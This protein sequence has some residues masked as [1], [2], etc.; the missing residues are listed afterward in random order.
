ML[1]IK[2]S[3]DTDETNELE[4]INSQSLF[5]S[6]ADDFR[7]WCLGLSGSYRGLTN[8]SQTRLKEAQS[9]REK[10]VRFLL[11]GDDFV[12]RNNT[13]Q[14]NESDILLAQTRK[15][16]DEDYDFYQTTIFHAQN[17]KTALS[18]CSSNS[19]SSTSHHDFDLDGSKFVKE[20][21]ELIQTGNSYI[22]NAAAHEP[23]GKHM[24]NV[25]IE[26]LQFALSTVRDLLSLVGFSMKTIQPGAKNNGSIT[27]DAFQSNIKGGEGKL[28]DEVI[29]MRKCM[30]EYALKGIK[31][32]DDETLQNSLKHILTL[33]DEMREISLPSLGIEV[34]DDKTTKE[35]S[36]NITTSRWRW[37]IPLSKEEQELEVKSLTEDTQQ[38][39]QKVK[40]ITKPENVT[41]ENFFQVGPYEDMY[42]EYDETGMPLTNMDGSKVSNKKKKKLRRK[43]ETFF[44]KLSNEG[45]GKS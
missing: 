23:G 20:L 32:K 27:D 6:P 15:W 10:V 5:Y 40:H 35:H 14:S 13:Q 36:T 44:S 17:C 2:P 30:R 19:E 22:S 37:R 8:Y 45:D 25:P 18:G 26:P 41:M 29:H 11:D 43:R 33:C 28:V 16:R 31:S 42:L 1:E 24:Q 38:T 39:N 4:E 7:L 12:Q 34:F 21:I 9:I 3:N